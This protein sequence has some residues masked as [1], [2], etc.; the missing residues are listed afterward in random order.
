MKKA[1]T[2]RQ[3]PFSPAHRAMKNVRLTYLLLGMLHLS[4]PRP[5]VR[6][7]KIHTLLSSI[8]VCA[9]LRSATGSAS[10]S[11]SITSFLNCFSPRKSAPVF[12]N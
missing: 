6:R 10:F 2:E 4:L 5:G 9:L 8:P 1:V 11:Y 3:K 12:N 7:G